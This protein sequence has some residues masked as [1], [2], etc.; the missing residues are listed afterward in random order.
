MTALTTL[1]YM[2]WDDWMFYIDSAVYWLR[3]ASS[4]AFTWYMVGRHRHIFAGYEDHNR[5]RKHALR[6]TPQTTHGGC[7]ETDR[8]ND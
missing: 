3:L 5:N 1:R 8:R 6:H 7:D 2:T 4:I